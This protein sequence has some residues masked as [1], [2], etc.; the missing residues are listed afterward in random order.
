MSHVSKLKNPISEV[1]D[2]QDDIKKTT[3]TTT[4]TTTITTITSP[5]SYQGTFVENC[6]CQR[7]VQFEPRC[8]F[9]R[10]QVRYL[11]WE[12]V[13]KWK[14]EEKREKGKRKRENVRSEKWEVKNEGES[15]SESEN[16]ENK[17]IGEWGVMVY[18]LWFMFYERW[19]MIEE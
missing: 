7:W 16:E 1:H 6:N 2:T 4:T 12:R 19:L 10:Y 18:G 9:S 14:V 8:H 13:W 17:R 11:F 15:E 3:T 5:M